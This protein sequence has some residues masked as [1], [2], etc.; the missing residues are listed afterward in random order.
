MIAT[1]NKTKG[2]RFNASVL[3]SETPNRHCWESSKLM[4][5]NKL[6]LPYNKF[7]FPSDSTLG[8]AS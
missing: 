2:C 7:V 6:C 1:E 4:P 5:C 3:I 8:S